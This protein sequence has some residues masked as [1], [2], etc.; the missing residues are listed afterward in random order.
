MPR[1]D[2]VFISLCII[3][4]LGYAVW[5]AMWALIPVFGG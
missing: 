2:F 4:S 1:P 3:G 5:H